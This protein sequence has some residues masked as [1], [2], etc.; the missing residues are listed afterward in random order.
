M[1]INNDPLIAARGANVLY[2]DVWSSMGEENQ[3]E[4]KDKDFNGFTIDKSLIKVA[5][6]EAIILHCYLLIEQKK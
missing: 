1:K 4:N 3:K 6:N 2:T 5:R